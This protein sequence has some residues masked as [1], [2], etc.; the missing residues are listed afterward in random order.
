M[1][2]AVILAGGKGTRLSHVVMD[3]PK[4]MAPINS[5]PF[6]QIL[7]DK[8]HEENFRRVVMSV[9][10]K[11]ENIVEFFG[12]SYK[13][14]EIVY[15]IERQPLGTGGATKISLA[16]CQ[17]QIVF[18]INGDTFLDFDPN[19]VLERWKLLQKP[20]VLAKEFHDA[21]RY[22]TLQMN[23][24]HVTAFIEKGI[25]GRGYINAG[26]YLFD[27]NLLCKKK[28]HLP[29]SL[30]KDVL[31][32]LAEKLLLEAYITEGQFIDIGVPADYAAAQKIFST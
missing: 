5:K 25:A 24:S 16:K 19:D 15:A 27:R 6:L 17:Q 32:E 4:P 18:V 22:G 2:E 11:Y 7:L 3:V 29:F 9:G 26:C 21:S 13:K 8:L 20:M 14:I 12:S 1:H 10:H 31:P 28:Q 30:E 23:G